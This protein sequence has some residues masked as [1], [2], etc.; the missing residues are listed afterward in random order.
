MSDLLARLDDLAAAG[1][2]DAVE[3]EATAALQRE[4]DDPDLWRYVAWARFETGRFRGALQAAQR[5]QDPLYAA[6]AHFHLWQFQEAARELADVAG[7]GDDEADAE[8]YRGLLAEFAGRAGDAHFQA[9]ARLAPGRYA[10]PVRL[11]ED[12]IDAVLQAAVDAL[13]P[14]VARAV[15]ETV[16]EVLDLPRP[17][18]DIDPLS[19]GL[20]WGTSRLERTVL[21]GASLP[22]RIE[23][24][25]RNIERIA[26]DR[27]EAIDELRIT[28][29]HEIGHHLGYGEEGLD[30]LGLG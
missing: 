14:D 13:P 6:M 25:R 10:V 12:E 30:V 9:A 8:W 17:H 5:G 24:Y 1:D 29:L 3:R 19:L 28:L 11:P 21:E 23:L 7:D 15:A 18:P 22:P 27:E 4:G 20:Y 26:A 2:L 16:V